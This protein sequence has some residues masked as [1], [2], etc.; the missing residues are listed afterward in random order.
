MGI[1]VTEFGSGCLPRRR[2]VGR[3]PSR[4]FL[5]DTIMASS[6]LPPVTLEHLYC[7]GD[8]SGV[9]WM[10]GLYVIAPQPET[11]RVPQLLLSQLNMAMRLNYPT[12]F[13]WETSDENFDC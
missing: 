9:G 8:G 11:A 1:T 5:L 7:P 3:F 12:R 2:T 4:N 6:T 13:L 10:D